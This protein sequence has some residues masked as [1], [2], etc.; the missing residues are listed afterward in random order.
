MTNPHLTAATVCLLLAPAITRA[1]H[2]PDHLHATGKAETKVAELSITKDG[3]SVSKAIKLY[4][5]PTEKQQSRLDR[6]PMDLG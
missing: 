1:D 4:G 5:E 2:L 3:E 6:L